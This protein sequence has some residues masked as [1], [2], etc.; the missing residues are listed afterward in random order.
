MS[1][2]AQFTMVVDEPRQRVTALATALK[3]TEPPQLKA[4]RLLFGHYW[5]PKEWEIGQNTLI[6][7][8]GWVLTA[9]QCTIQINHILPYQR[10][11]PETQYGSAVING[12]NY[13]GQFFQVSETIFSHEML[14]IPDLPLMDL[15]NVL[16]S[17]F[18]EANALH[19]VHDAYFEDG[20]WITVGL[21]IQ[22][23]EQQMSR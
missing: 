19:E 23:P 2:H 13:F 4:T 1:T 21:P 10:F 14:Q 17:R 16:S 18:A 15:L 6:G 22:L 8:G 5:K 9:A 7:P 20:C 11:A 3:G 12:I